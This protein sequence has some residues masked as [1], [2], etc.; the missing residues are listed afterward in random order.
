M[1]KIVAEVMREIFPDVSRAE[2][3]FEKTV[4]VRGTLF[5][6]NQDRQNHE[7]LL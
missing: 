1:K 2:S 6:V 5:E 3:S 4:R 7:P